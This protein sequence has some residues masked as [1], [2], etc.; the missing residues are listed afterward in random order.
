[1]SRFL[2]YRL[3]R[4]LS[5]SATIISLI[6]LLSRAVAPD[7]QLA[8]RLAEGD[9]S[10]H[11]VSARQ[12]QQ[13]E[14]AL[15]ERQGLTEPLFY[16]SPAQAPT[17]RLGTRWRWNGHRNQY[18][19][20]L[21]QL[22]RAD[23]GTSL[24]SAQPVTALLGAALRY[25]LPLTLS[26]AAATGGIAWLLA[27]SLGRYRRRRAL[28]LAGAFALDALP[29][30]VTALLLLLLLANPDALT[31]FPAYGLGQEDPT[32]PWPAQFSALAY[33]LALPAVALV[34]ASLPMLVVQ[35]DAALQQELRADYILTAQAKGLPP[36]LVVRRHALRNAM[37]PV[38]ALLTELLPSLVAGAV[39]VELVFSL[40]GMGRLLAEAAAARDYPVLLGSVLVV[41]FVRL[42]AQVLTDVLYR[43]ADPRIR[44][45]L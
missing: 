7:Q 10:A 14:Y 9:L 4:L 39:V 27:P 13:A 26:A 17:A 2:L 35:L 11:V 45:S 1:M 32:L 22:L 41:S 19:H 16:F 43:L 18:H 31:W 3:L 37:L 8:G 25:T 34:L 6:F 20:W 24:R 28:L 29:L 30:F 44:L 40:P 23:L 42:L 38:L 12:R 5:A 33:H 21:R 15:R 36:A